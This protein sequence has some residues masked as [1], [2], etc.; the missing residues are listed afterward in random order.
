MSLQTLWKLLKQS[1]QEFQDDKASQLA[2]ALSYYTAVSIAPMLIFLLLILGFVMGQDVA[3]SQLV[4]QL[5]GVLGSEGMEFINTIIENAEQ[6]TAGSIAGILSLLTLI[7]GSAN[8]FS[9]LQD[10]LNV[11]WDVTIKPSGGWKL[12]LRKR[13]L[14][15]TLVLGIGFLLAVSLVLSAALS[16]ISSSLSGLLP[17]FDLLWQGVEYAISF[18]VMMLLFAAMFK[19]LPDVHIPWRIVWPGAMV[20]AL[21]FTI[22]K[23]IL[24]LYIGQAAPGSAYGT[25]GSVIVFLLWV[26]YSAMILFFG[27]EITQVYAAQRGESIQ[28]EEHAMFADQPAPL[29]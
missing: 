28:P 14:S 4:R 12:T 22:G 29:N 13:L 20:T 10:T 6:P 9:H 5:E 16:L 21:L 24:S 26:Y 8:V 23:L 15:F 27:A 3:Q 25:A 1:Y 11:I 17:S 18:G 19:V 7:W 2:A